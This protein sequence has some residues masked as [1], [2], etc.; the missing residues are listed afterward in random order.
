MIDEIADFSLTIRYS[1]KEIYNKILFT[2]SLFNVEER[3]L[4]IGHYL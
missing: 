4:M 3:E 2:I 1:A